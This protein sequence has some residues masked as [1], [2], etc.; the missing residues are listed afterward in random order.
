[1][2]LA[3]CDLFTSEELFQDVF[4]YRP[5]VGLDA[6]SPK[7]E[8]LGF[9][10]RNFFF[11]LGD[12]SIIQFY[13]LYLSIKAIF[14]KCGCIKACNTHKNETMTE[15]F[16]NWP[17]RFII[18]AYIELSIGSLIKFFSDEL[19]FDHTLVD[20]I[21]TAFAYFYL[22]ILPLVPTILLLV[23]SVKKTVIQ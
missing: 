1:M 8:A 19:S 2:G 3:A 21:D 15:L 23:L 6:H 20:S 4:Q 14:Q 10:T 13:P 12:I 9:D 7:F 18:M 11:N 5:T 22:V 16:W 17:L